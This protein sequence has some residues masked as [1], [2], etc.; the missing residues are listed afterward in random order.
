MVRIINITFCAFCITFK[1]THNYNQHINCNYSVFNYKA[2]QFV[3]LYT[4]IEWCYDVYLA[5][6]LNCCCP[7]LIYL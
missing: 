5:T 2:T 7:E 3:V 4:M 6:Q 1:Y